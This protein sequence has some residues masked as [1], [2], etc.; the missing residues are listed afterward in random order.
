MEMF[1]EARRSQDKPVFQPILGP[2]QAF[3]HWESS[4]G[5]LLLLAVAVAL[6]W[7]N[8][9]WAESYTVFWNMPV[10]LVVGSHALTESLLEWINEGLMAMF[11]FVVGLEIKQEILVGELASPR[12][13][14]PSFH[15]LPP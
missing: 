7:A 1:P 4:G 12:H 13:A 11:F 6:V 5:I 8:S 14:K 2:F 9:P 3:V 10:S 15:W